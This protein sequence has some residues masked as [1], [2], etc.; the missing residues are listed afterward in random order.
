MIMEIFATIGF[1][2][3]SK[4]L[5]RKGKK[6]KQKEEDLAI[7]AQLEDEEKKQQQKEV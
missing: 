5:Y 6:N 3:Y 1:I 4:W 2:G 7:L